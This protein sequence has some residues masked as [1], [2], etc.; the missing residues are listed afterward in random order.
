MSLNT[1]CPQ[2]YKEFKWPHIKRLG[3]KSDKDA[4][5]IEKNP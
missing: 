2:K 4:T 5:L 3:F 1:E